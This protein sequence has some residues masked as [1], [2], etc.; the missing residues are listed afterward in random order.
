MYIQ[1]RQNY[2][3]DVFFPKD[4]SPGVIVLPTNP[5]KRIDMISD[6]LTPEGE[7]YGDDTSIFNPDNLKELEALVTQQKAALD[8]EN[9]EKELYKKFSVKR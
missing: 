3:A 1:Y 8:A 7:M 2:D 5:Q 9:A 4:D 6:Y